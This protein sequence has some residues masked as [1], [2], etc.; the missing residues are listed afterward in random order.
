MFTR[1]KRPG[2]AIFP[3]GARWPMAGFGLSRSG[4]LEYTERMKST[5]V[6]LGMAAV[7]L[8]A[9]G[10][11]IA[12]ERDPIDLP[13]GGAVMARLKGGHPRLM[14][15]AGDFDRL[16]EAVS[17]EGDLGS[18][19]KRLR[20][21]ADDICGQA[22]SRYEIPDGLRLLSTSR[23]VL[24]RA[25]TLAFAHRMTG[26]RRYADRLAR[27]LETA[28]GFKDW[29]PRHFLDT[30]EMAHAFAIGYDWLWDYWT[31]EQKRMLREAIMQKAFEPALGLYRKNSGWTRARHNWNQVCNGGLGIAALAVGPEMPEAAGEILAGALRSVR[32]PMA[33]FD[34]DGAWQEGPGYWNYA[35]SYNVYFLAALETALGTDFGLSAAPGFGETGWFPIYMTGPLGRTFNYADGGDSPIRAPQMFWLAR[36]FQR[37][38]F[39]AYQARIAAPHV[40]DLVWRGPD[41]PLMSAGHPPLDKWFRKAEVVTMR[42]A[43]GS[44][45]ALFIGFKGGDNKANHSNLDL[46]T[47]V[48][49]ALGVRWAVDLGAGNYNLPGYF[50]SQRWTYYRLRAEGH[51]TLV[52]NPGPEPDQAPKASAKVVRFSSEP[53]RAMAVADLTEAY[54]PHA[55]S[56]KRGIARLG[57]GQALVQDELQAAKPV[58]FWWFMHTRAE[59]SVEGREAW[60]RQDGQRLRARIL[61]PAGARFEALEAAP[62]PGTPQ[63]ARQDS[64]RGVRKLAIHLPAAQDL[65]LAVWLVPLRPDETGPG[66]APE[67]RPLAEW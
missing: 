40:L 62:L 42:D 51:N 21:S 26:D 60:L 20:Q 12:A 41:A 59:I 33:E 13:D 16:R 49:D 35:T 6:L 17:R 9:L 37:P 43:W 39:A 55:S 24:Q 25:Y 48:L 53:G 66:Q 23:R 61:E 50:G 67:V 14:A 3:P 52:L 4:R 31:A 28:A 47:F 2:K 19:W 18:G 36:R 11:P 64:N 54:A 30:A 8:A 5:G 46:G 56:V 32:L 65:R 29:N 34:P 15:S 57:A 22:P 63:P 58:D 44:Q 38:E 27:E 1:R 45:D 10:Q 7:W